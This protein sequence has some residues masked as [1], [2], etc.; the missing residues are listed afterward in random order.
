M[1]TKET[2]SVIS[3]MLCQGRR[4]LKSNRP[5]SSSAALEEDLAF[6]YLPVN[7]FGASLIYFQKKSEK[8][9]VWTVGFS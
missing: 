3:A 5:A 1:S 8:R 4:P 9:R 2:R 7:L 6:F